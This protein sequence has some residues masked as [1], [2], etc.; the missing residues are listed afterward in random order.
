MKQWQIQATG[1][2]SEGGFDALACV[3]VD[4]RRRGPARCWSGCGPTHELS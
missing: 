2:G 3:E 4:E 1:G